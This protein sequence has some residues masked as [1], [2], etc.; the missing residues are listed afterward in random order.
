MMFRE[1]W[2][3]CWPIIVMYLLGLFIGS[4]ITYAILT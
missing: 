3:D 1:F 4:A 2:Q